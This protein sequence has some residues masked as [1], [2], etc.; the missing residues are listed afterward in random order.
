MA[1]RNSVLHYRTRGTTA[2]IAENLKV[3]EIAMSY[4]K[5]HEKLFIKNTSD[6]VVSF[7]SEGQV[8]GK[9][10]IKSDIGH[11]HV[12][13]DITDFPTFKTV[14][15]QIITGSG[16]VTTDWSDVKNKPIPSAGNATTTQIVMGNDTRLTDARNANDVYSWAK[17]ETKPS[18]TKSEVGLGNVDNTSDKDKPVSI[19]TQQALDTK[20]NWGS[21][22]EDYHIEDGVT[23]TE[24][25][26]NLTVVE[27]HFNTQDEKIANAVGLVV[28][29]GDKFNEYTYASDNVMLAE[30][31]TAS[32]SIDYLA[33]QLKDCLDLIEELK[34]NIYMIEANF[35]V[36]PDTNFTL[37]NISYTLTHNGQPVNPNEVT[38]TKIV[39][40]GEPIVLF[41]SPQSASAF[42]SS[43]SGA[44]EYFSLLAKPDSSLGIPTKS[45]IFRYLCYVGTSTEDSMKKSIFRS[46]DRNV[47]DGTGFNKSVSTN[48]GE[49]VWIVVPKQLQVV[50]VTHGG[51]T[52]SLANPQEVVDNVTVE[53]I[54]NHVAKGETEWWIDY[55]KY[56]NEP[57]T[58]DN[59]EFVEVVLD[60]E[61][62]IVWGKRVDGSI[63]EPDMSPYVL[64]DGLGTFSAYRS[65]KQL[66]AADWD[67]VIKNL[68]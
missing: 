28:T 42:T 33:G 9:V 15:G 56:C 16:N 5:D 21:T 68:A 11:K 7:I 54:V 6:E 46:F 59:P 27:E 25:Q 49:Y 29:T 44:K 35:Q 8:N 3:G 58:I 43:I 65:L 66:D 23:K 52:F 57:T 53:D 39:N 45:E 55:N 14:N 50:S 61:D 41:N 48:R 47:S 38:I 34:T 32:Q 63:Y 31:H 30:C 37:E 64:E 2:P 1:K 67:L 24:L 26:T 51:I 22:L 13:G 62:K 12:K 18:Y 40:D 36:T 19:A 4:A 10:S 60:S 20:A 17:Q